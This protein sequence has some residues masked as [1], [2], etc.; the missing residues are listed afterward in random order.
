MKVGKLLAWVREKS[1][2]SQ[3]LLAKKLKKSETRV[4]RIEND[5]T[6]LNNNEINAYLKP[7]GTSEAIDLNSYLK[8]DWQRLNKPNFFNPSRKSLWLAESALI[9]LKTMN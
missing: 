9:K 2:M 1:G 3:K 6:P 7:I 5:E 8:Q 4:S